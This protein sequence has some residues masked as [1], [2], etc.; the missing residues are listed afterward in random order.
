M[1]MFD[2]L[3]GA[4]NAMT[5]GGA[6]VSIEFPNETIAPGEQVNVRIT[7]R[8]TGGDIKS[9]GVFVDILAQEHGSFRK[10]VKCDQCEHEDE[11]TIDFPKKKTMEKSYLIAPAFELQAN[12]TKVIDGSFQIPG[13]AKPTYKGAVSHDWSIRGR[14]EAFGNDPDSGFQSMRVGVR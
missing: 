1:G 3:K 12:E 10:R 11:K 2:K 5:G 4:V 6:D 8:S 13:D 14:L 7:V 9:E